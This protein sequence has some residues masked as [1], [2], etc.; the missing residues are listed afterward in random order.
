MIRGLKGDDFRDAKEPGF[1]GSP[2]FHRKGLAAYERYLTPQIQNP[3]L[4]V[5]VSSV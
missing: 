1:F 3:D 2:A 4:H 5:C